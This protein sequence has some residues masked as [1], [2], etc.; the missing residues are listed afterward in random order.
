MFEVLQNSEK[1]QVRNFAL[2]KLNECYFIPVLS[3]LLNF[4]S[5]AITFSI[6][7]CSEMVYLL[8]F[9]RSNFL[10]SAVA[11]KK[12]QFR[13]SSFKL[14]EEFSHRPQHFSC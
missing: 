11:M 1:V 10:Q 6:M 14:T 2:L 13:K 8:F 12:M 5:S 9:T 4:R 7:I 3:I